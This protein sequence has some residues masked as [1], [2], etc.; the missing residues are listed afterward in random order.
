METLDKIPNTINPKKDI[1]WKYKTEY[2]ETRNGY[3][4]VASGIIPKIKKM[5]SYV[6]GSYIPDWKP[7]EIGNEDEREK[8]TT[9]LPIQQKKK[10]KR[11]CLFMFLIFVILL[12]IYGLVK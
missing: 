1:N 8:S 6:I 2:I 9:I 12:I 10:K 4:E 11:S 3:K 7:I 5:N